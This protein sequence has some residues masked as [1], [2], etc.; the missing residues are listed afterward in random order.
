MDATIELKIKGQTLEAI[1]WTFVIISLT[2]IT[3]IPENGCTTK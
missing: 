1:T 2:A 3:V